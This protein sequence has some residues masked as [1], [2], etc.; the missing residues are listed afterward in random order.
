MLLIKKKKSLILSGKM[1]STK[2]KNVF[3]GQTL[4]GNMPFTLVYTI[5]IQASRVVKLIY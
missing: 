2:G 5:N 3:L 4:G 1:F